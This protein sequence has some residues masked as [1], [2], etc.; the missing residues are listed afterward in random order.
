MSLL[1]SIVFGIVSGISEFLP[2]SSDAHQKMMLCLFGIEGTDPVRD[3]IV[4]IAALI[5]LLT[6]TKS[7][8]S[9]INRER[10]MAQNGARV[11]NRVYRGNKDFRLIKTAITPLIIVFLALRYITGS[12]FTLAHTAAMLLLNGI[13]LFIPGRLL[14]GNKDARSMSAMDGFLL[15]LC[16]SLSAFPGLSR[17]GLSVSISSIRGAER[18]HCISWAYL[19][20]IPM[21]AILAAFDLLSL[22]AGLGTFSFSATFFGYILIGLSTFISSYISVIT[23]KNFISGTDYSV[24]SYYSWGAALFSFILYLI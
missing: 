2:I 20:S 13:I 18:Q 3:M 5:A 6:A 8:L 14:Q 12:N 17:I 9:T 7:L 19:L 22:F 21:L 10:K 15:G 16:S 4:H 24:F 11:Y 23:F 1:Q